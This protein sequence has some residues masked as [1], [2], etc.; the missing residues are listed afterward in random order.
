ML[1]SL[2]LEADWPRAVFRRRRHGLAKW[3]T[4]D[5]AAS[6]HGAPIFP[7]LGVN[8]VNLFSLASAFLN[9]AGFCS[10]PPPAPAARR[11]RSG[12]HPLLE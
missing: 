4:G 12:N 8:H 3:G 2:R 7:L 9:G 5:P 6:E 10:L 11:Q 1:D